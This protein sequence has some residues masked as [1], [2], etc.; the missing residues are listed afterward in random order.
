[1]SIESEVA[2]LTSEATR[3]FGAVNTAKA[4]VESAVA[5]AIEQGNLAAAAKDDIHQNWS[6]K[7]AAAA[8]AASTSTS[9]ASTATAKA[10]IATSA[11]STA[12]SQAELATSSAQ[13]AI[14]Q[15][16]VAVRRYSSVSD[17]RGVVGSTVFIAAIT[18]GYA[19]AGDDGGGNWRW[20][21]ASTETD[22]NGTVIKPTAIASNAAGRWLRVTTTPVDPKWF[23]AKGDGTTDDTAALQAAIDYAIT[24][25][26]GTGRRAGHL[27][28]SPGIYRTTAPLFLYYLS[29]GKYVG[30]SL[31]V[32]A[33]TPGYI[34][35]VYTP[36]R[37]SGWTSGNKTVIRAD[38]VDAP[39]LIV[40]TCRYVQFQNFDISSAANRGEYPNDRQ[41]L[42]DLGAGGNA[43][44]GQLTT[45][46]PWWLQRYLD[47]AD[48]GPLYFSSDARDNR[49]SPHGCVVIDPF[50]STD[51]TLANAYPSLL[52]Q[53]WYDAARFSSSTGT[54]SSIV[55][56]DRMTFRQAIVGVAASVASG[57]VNGEFIT[58]Y[59]CNWFGCKSAVALGSSQ[60]KGCALYDSR[61]EAVQT[62]VNLNDYGTGGAPFP[63]VEQ[64]FTTSG[65]KWFMRANVGNQSGAI[66]DFYCEGLLSLGYWGSNG[67]GGRPL[68]LINTTLK[69]SLPS[70]LTGNV[71][72]SSQT[73]SGMSSPGS[74][75]YVGGAVFG[76][77]IPPG[78]TVTAVGTTTLTI[79]QAATASYT[80][81]PIYGGVFQGVPPS[82]LNNLAPVNFIG[83]SNFVYTNARSRG[84]YANTNN[85]I[86]FSGT[87]LDGEPYSI[88]RNLCRFDNCTLQDTGGAGSYG[89]TGKYQETLSVLGGTVAGSPTTPM[90]VRGSPH[91][92][93]E[94]PLNGDY[95]RYRN[96]SG[97]KD[98]TVGSCVIT[99]DAWSGTAYFT[100][101]NV[102]MLRV[103]DFVSTSTTWYSIEDC[104]TK[105]NLNS[106]SM[107]LVNGDGTL[108]PE[109]VTNGGFDVGTGW[110]LGTGWSIANGQA[111]KA[112]ATSASS[113]TQAVAGLVA[114][115]TY[116]VTLDLA[117]ITGG[118]S[119]NLGDSVALV[120]LTGGTTVSQDIVQTGT[121]VPSGVHTFDLVAN[122]GNTTLG[123]SSLIPARPA[124]GLSIGRV[125]EIDT[126]TN[127]VYLTYVPVS[128]ESGTYTVTM[129]RLPEIRQR[130]IGTT[131]SGSADITNVTPTAGWAVS[132]R[133]HGAGIPDGAYITAV[134][135]TTLTISAN[136]TASGTVELF[137]AKLIVDYHARSTSPGANIVPNGGFDTD[138]VWEKVGS[139]TIVNSTARL[140]AVNAAVQ[141]DNVIVPG[142]SYNY[143]I[144][145]SVASGTTTLRFYAGTGGSYGRAVLVQSIT[146]PAS[147]VLTG[148]LTAGATETGIKVYSSANGVTLELDEVSL[149]LADTVWIQGDFVTN[150]APTKDA[151]NMSLRGWTCTASGAPGSWEPVYESVVSPAT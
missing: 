150:S 32:S 60:N 23:G 21:A 85:N 73:I 83:G 55:T 46:I 126:V 118:W 128:F 42:Y 12:Q 109:L 40:Q 145:Y 147:G 105:M 86:T 20:D 100:T 104:G 71:T 101:A 123:V 99:V 98:Y 56:C 81:T 103:G 1:M 59:N 138:T 52:A 48:G 62:F 17:L 80:A 115:S 76:R 43:T 114:G 108:G 54:G 64:G 18:L 57:M 113:L 124:T 13:S 130:T 11:A 38:H 10:D 127:T 15:L 4:D 14:S 66:K 5:T 35:G 65:H 137:D 82:R 133:I 93:I 119:A 79:S 30:F 74:H 67:I 136:A 8:S 125:N 34:G 6:D 144:T 27:R 95:I 39:A 132:K 2:A 92:T 33:D 89:L 37:P 53:G 45:S 9:A 107:K 16:D 84:N 139:A 148:T 96:I 3:L 51:I 90:T 88:S 140:A 25:S 135:G 106:I 61:V 141:Q 72:A 78:T 151:N 77:G 69:W 102:W 146:G 111:I 97:W 28:L 7:L 50:N 131:T 49:F 36:D 63:L 87:Y 70:G 142:K 120:Q 110:T 29:A 24:S 68:N 91:F 31:T 121:G 44:L 134:N 47:P 143:A 22:N 122:T 75:F 116:R 117:S 129:S 41:A 149:T 112:S 58:F 19:T 26:V 94:A